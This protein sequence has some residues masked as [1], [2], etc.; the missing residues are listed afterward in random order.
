MINITEVYRAIG[1]MGNEEVRSTPNH[2]S[3]GRVDYNYTPKVYSNREQKNYLIRI[4]DRW[5]IAK[6][7]G[8]GMFIKPKNKSFFNN[9]YI[10]FDESEIDEV[11]EF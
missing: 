5:V 9:T 2:R 1:W 4:K 7:V 6:Y 8:Q 3:E 11:Y 10:G